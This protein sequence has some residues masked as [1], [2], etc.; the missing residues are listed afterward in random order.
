MAA[1]DTLKNSLQRMTADEKAKAADKEFVR[2]MKNRQAQ[3]GAHRRVREMV[4]K[5]FGK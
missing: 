5:E 1:S 4:D 3:I 2:F